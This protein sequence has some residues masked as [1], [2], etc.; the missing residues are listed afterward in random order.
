M[1]QQNYCDNVMD[2][3]MSDRLFLWIIHPSMIH[4]LPS[5]VKHVSL[6]QHVSVLQKMLCS[7]VCLLFFLH[8]M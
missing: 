5:Q 3:C 8:Y 7:F 4:V 6:Q 1:I 2:I